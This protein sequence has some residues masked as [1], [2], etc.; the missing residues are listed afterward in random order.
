MHIR[1]GFVIDW[2]LILCGAVAFGTI[3]TLLLGVDRDTLLRYS[4]DLGYNLADLLL[5]GIIPKR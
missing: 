2:T 5:G 1:W 4:H 3:T